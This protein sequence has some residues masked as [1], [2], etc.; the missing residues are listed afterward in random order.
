MDS[1]KYCI[2]CQEQIID[3]TVRIHKNKQRHRINVDEKLFELTQCEK[4]KP[5]NHHFS[6]DDLEISCQVCQV[7]VP[8]AN[9]DEHLN[10]SVHDIKFK[11]LLKGNKMIK[12]KNIIQCKVCNCIVLQVYEIK[13]TLSSKHIINLRRFNSEI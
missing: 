10:S 6:R 1:T 12:T 4:F 3:T 11:T 13:H 5:I 9:L 7:T 8:A 2:F